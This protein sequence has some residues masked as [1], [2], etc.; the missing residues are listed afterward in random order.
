MQTEQ[1]TTLPP[2][3]GVVGSLKAGFD[4]IAANISV[5]LLPVLLDLWL[6]LGPHV[7]VDH[8]FKPFFDEMS[9]YSALSGLP[10]A[11]VI[12]VQEAYATISVELQ[13]YNLMS[14][15]RTFPIGIFSLMSGKM[16]AETPLGAISVIHVDSPLTLLGWMAL[17]TLAGWISGGFFFRWVSVV[18]ADS[19][20]PEPFRLGYSVLQTILLSGLCIFLTFMIGIPVI[21]TLALVIVASPLLAQVVLLIL[22][23]ISMWLVVPL[24][25]S[26]HGIFM[27]QENAFLSV[28]TSLRLARFTLP[29]SSLFVLSVLLI[30]YGLNYLWSIPSSSSW[31]AFVGIA[32]HAFITTSLLAASFIYYRDMQIW[33][34][35]VFTK[36]KATTPPQSV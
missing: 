26:P 2:P 25:F 7:R 12:R 20:K 6:W 35:T 9:K 36:M 30:A 18:V 5:I 34:Q 24:F 1:L 3:P 16:P 4:A 19:S 23:L 13:K 29:T 31:M 21:L 27:R 17:L 15:L 33:L 11:D 28:Y 22:G 14:I 32:G 8:L 10:S